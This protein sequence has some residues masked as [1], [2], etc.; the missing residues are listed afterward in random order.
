[1][2]ILGLALGNLSPSKLMNMND[3]KLVSKIIQYPPI[4]GVFNIDFPQFCTVSI[5]L[6]FVHSPKMSL[7]H[8]VLCQTLHIAQIPFFCTRSCIMHRY[9]PT[10]SKAFVAFANISDEQENMNECFRLFFAL[11]VTFG[12]YC[13]HL[14]FL[15]TKLGF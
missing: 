14:I 9:C 4:Y 12:I 2:N 5:F 3:K 11:L 10:L 13:S 7:K 15:K 6:K 1:M 8:Q